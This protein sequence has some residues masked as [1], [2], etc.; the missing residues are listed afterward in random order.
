[1]NLW[2]YFALWGSFLLAT[3]VGLRYL[4]V[5]AARL[6]LIAG[7]LTIIARKPR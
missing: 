5:I 7:A 6:L 1:M 2:L 3:L 4:Y